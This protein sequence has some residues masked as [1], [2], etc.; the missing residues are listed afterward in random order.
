MWREPGRGCG[1]P[2]GAGGWPWGRSGPAEAGAAG[3]R[4][5]PGKGEP[6][7]RLGCN[8]VACAG[9]GT[10]EALRAIAWAGYQ[11]VE[12]SPQHLSPDDPEAARAAV[13][14]AQALGLESVAIEAAGNLFD[15]RVRTRLCRYFSLAGSLGIPLVSTGSGGPPSPEGLEGFVGIARTLAAEAEARGVRWALKAH[16]GAAVHGTDDLLAVLA[17][18]PAPAL[19]VNFDAT[20]LQR[21]GETP[22]AS[23]RRLG[24][25]IGHVH[26]RDY[27][28][29]D[30]KIGPP[31]GQIPGRGRVDLPALL[32]ALRAA[33]YD[34]F[35][36]LEIIGA[37]GWPAVRQ[38]GLIAEGR[39]YLHRLLRELAGTP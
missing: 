35:L 19:V 12:F 34:G 33:G 16:V 37:Q 32:G 1:A 14:E 3:V 7:L 31:E 5:G 36:D 28:S 21:Q 22:A 29:P 27:D 11:G 6:P 23:V 4:L 13:A 10:A 25:R 8:T 17:A 15:E 26:I 30:L 9:Q 38:M 39:G 18:V 2:A 20:H 24:Q